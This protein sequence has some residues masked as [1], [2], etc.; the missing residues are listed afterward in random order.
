MKQGA[1]VVRKTTENLSPAQQDTLDAMK[2][3]RSPWCLNKNTAEA[4]LRR[5]LIVPA[6]VC[7][8][9]HRDPTYVLAPQTGARR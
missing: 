3:N 1:Q 6:G 9:E 8:D 2:A 4:L 7:C 5:G